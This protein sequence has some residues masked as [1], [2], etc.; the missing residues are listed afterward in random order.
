M[1]REYDA[2]WFEIDFTSELLLLLT[3]GDI[4]KQIHNI[5]EYHI[6]EEQRRRRQPFIYISDER[7]TPIT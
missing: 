4:L 2:D 5:P 7:Y 6:L 3:I 1:L